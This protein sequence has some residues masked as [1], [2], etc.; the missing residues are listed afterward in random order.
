[1][2]FYLML[3]ATFGAAYLVNWASHRYFVPLF[4]NKEIGF[5]VLM[6]AIFSIGFII[7]RYGSKHP[8]E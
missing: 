2:K 7:D 3:G 5:V 1:M 4:D 8:N 6:T